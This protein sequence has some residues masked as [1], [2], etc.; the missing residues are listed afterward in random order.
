[1]T[2]MTHDFDGTSGYFGDA[3]QVHLP[4]IFPPF[5]YHEVRRH[6]GVLACEASLFKSKF[7]NVLTMMMVGSLG[8]AAVEN[9]VSIG[10]GAEAGQMDRSLQRL[11]ARYCGQSLILTRNE[12]SQTVLSSLGVPSELGTDT[13]WTFEPHGPEFGRRAL[14]EAGWDGHAPVLAVCPIDPFCWPA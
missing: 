14:S 2:V 5:L 3:A 4:N 1:M 9:K 6:H 10:Y 11:C 13:A 8:I 7:T 12:A